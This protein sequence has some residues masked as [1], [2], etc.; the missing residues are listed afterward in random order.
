[1]DVLAIWSKLHRYPQRRD[2]VRTPRTMGILR[3]FSPLREG[4]SASQ[5]TTCGQVFAIAHPAGEARLY[6]A[7]V[8]V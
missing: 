5:H 6:T 4:S 3:K 8:R 7:G 2:W 1:M